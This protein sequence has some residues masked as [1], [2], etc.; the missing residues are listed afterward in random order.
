MDQFWRELFSDS[1]LCPKEIRQMD[2]RNV[3]LIVF[4]GIYSEAGVKD[5]A[6]VYLNLMLK[7]MLSKICELCIKLILFLFNTLG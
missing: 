2:Y 5:C 3:D 4:L 1:V 7:Y 6:V